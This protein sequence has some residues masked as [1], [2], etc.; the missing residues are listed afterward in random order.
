MLQSQL[1]NKKKTG[2]LYIVGTGPGSSDILTG[3]AIR[4]LKESDIIIGNDFYIDKIMDIISDK[5]II[6]SKMGK[7]VDRA[8]QAVILAE[9]KIVSMVSGG[10]PGIFGMA[11]I[12]LEV[13]M[14]MNSNANIKVIPGISAANMGA[15]L[16]GAPLSIDF[17]TISLSDLLTPWDVIV[18]RLHAVFSVKMPVV[19]YNPKS[20]TRTTQYGEAINIALKYLP[21]KTPVGIVKNAAREGEEVLITTLIEAESNEDFVDMHST[22]FIGGEETCIYQQG[23]EQFIVTPRGYH[24]KY[25]Y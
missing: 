4:V 9:E 21:E 18:K 19:L 11:G 25:D 16:L 12:V 5:E 10:D 20:R 8:K 15:S 1:Q 23:D 6:R 3:L 24:R 17:A 7:E 2:T 14:H 13:A 22:V